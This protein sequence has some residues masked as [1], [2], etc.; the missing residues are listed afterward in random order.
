MGQILR[1]GTAQT[2][3]TLA[4][5]VTALGNINGTGAN[6]ILIDAGY[7]INEDFNAAGINSGT[8]T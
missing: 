1:V 2:Y 6:E 5:A 7:A 3:T 4:S 8:S